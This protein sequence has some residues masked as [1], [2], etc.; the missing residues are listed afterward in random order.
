MLKI[1]VPV[2]GSDTSQ[3]AV[4]HVI[5]L[6]Q[7]YKDGA[8]IHLINVQPSLP[9]GGRV[10]AV[11]GHGNIEEYHREEGMKA[12]QPARQMLD[13]AGVKYHYHIA[14][15]DPA[16]VIA[17]YGKQHGIDQVVM[18]TNGRSA[19]ASVLMGSVAKE[20]LAKALVPVVLVK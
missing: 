6:T 18:G 1:L 14:V 3:R 5:S 13:A 16:E 15:G 11:V 20:V 10:S 9:F 2:D 12:L 19:V 17:Q 8:D 4:G 7:L